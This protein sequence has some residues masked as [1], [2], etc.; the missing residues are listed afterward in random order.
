MTFRKSLRRMFVAVALVAALATPAWAITTD[1]VIQMHKSGLPAQVIVQTIQSTGSTFNLTVAELKKL[2]DAGV[3]K[4]VIEAMMAS[5][6]GGAPAPAPE[7]APEPAPKDDL[8]RLRD[9]E[10]A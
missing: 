3:P 9:Q 6:G 1:N 4:D 2:E 5:G 10:E 8:E 7:P